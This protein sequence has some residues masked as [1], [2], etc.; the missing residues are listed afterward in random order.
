MIYPYRLI[1]AALL[2]VS[3]STKAFSEFGSRVSKNQVYTLYRNSVLDENNRI[4]V[5]TFDADE[6]ESY[7]KG[8]CDIAQ[9][10]FQQ[11]PMVKVKYWC[12]KGY[13]KK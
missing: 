7:N 4:H 5:A 10:L 1:I 3:G 9:G 2:V 12:E 13:F 8:S 6:D 11:Q